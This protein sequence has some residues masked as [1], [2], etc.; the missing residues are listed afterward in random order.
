[1]VLRFFSELS[2]DEIARQ[3]DRPLGTIK[4]HLHRGLLRLRGAV[5]PEE[6]S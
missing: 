2:L 4:T 6:A 3:L 5:A 1:V